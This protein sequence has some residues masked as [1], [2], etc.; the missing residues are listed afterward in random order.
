MNI[1]DSIT[2]RRE[3]LETIHHEELQ[4]WIDHVVF[5]WRWWL[6]V[7]FI[8]VPIV[9]WLLLRKKDSTDR[10]LYI[11]LFI[12]TI[13]AYLDFIGV[14]FGLWD[15]QYEVFPA[16]KVFFPWN[17]IVLPVTIMFLFQIKPNINPWIKAFIYGGLTSFVALPLFTYMSIYKPLHWN[18]LYSLPIQIILYMLTYLLSKRDKFASFQ[19]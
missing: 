9:I 16:I 15:Y 1:A 12:S 10:S 6:G 3:L 7:S 4:Y 8:F 2:K 19:K 18:Y 5:T 14:Y 13:S 11:G 17:S